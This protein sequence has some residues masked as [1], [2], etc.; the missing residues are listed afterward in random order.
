[1]HCKHVET[2][3]TD[4][5]LLISCIT[6]LLTVPRSGTHAAKPAD[7]FRPSAL[8][9][10]HDIAVS[11]PQIAIALLG[12]LLLC[13]SALANRDL[14]QAPQQ[15]QQDLPQ[16]PGGP[17]VN[18]AATSLLQQAMQGVTS[19]LDY[20]AGDQQKISSTPKP[21]PGAGPSPC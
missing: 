9:V 8:E 12:A 2:T 7:V 20:S 3:H 21:Q 6:I 19:L 16:L 4:A 5:C 10:T 13:T 11:L 14:K 15:L 18:N 1:M 17:A